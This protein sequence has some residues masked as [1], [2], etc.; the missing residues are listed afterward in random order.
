MKEIEIEIQKRG[1]ILPGNVLKVNSFLNHQ[2]D[3]V[4]LDKMADQWY[5]LFKND[6]VTKIITIEASGIALAVLT[7]LKFKV[8]VIFAKKSE[9]SNI[10]KTYK[11]LIYSYT[12]HQSFVINIEK[13]FLTSDDRVLIIDDFLANGSAILGMIDIINQANAHLVGVGIAIEKGFQEGGKILR[14]KKIRVE[15]LAIIDS[16]DDEAKKIHFKE[17]EKVVD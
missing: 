6:N 13:E 4:F 2:L 5:N 16:M 14:D 11:S 17:M 15:S 12:R 8:P 10:G 3:P 9:S 1:K 7:G